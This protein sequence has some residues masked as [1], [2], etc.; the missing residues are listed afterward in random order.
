MLG[1]PEALELGP[2]AVETTCSCLF[3]HVS[4][5]VILAPCT[6]SAPP[7]CALCLCPLMPTALFMYTSTTMLPISPLMLGYNLSSAR[8]QLQMVMCPCHMTI[9]SS[10][11]T[12][13]A[14]FDPASG[15]KSE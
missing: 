5:P 13:G 10:V 7:S 14:S 15:S 9:L 1:A 8:S 11:W 6:H 3:V 2:D 12:S 4:T